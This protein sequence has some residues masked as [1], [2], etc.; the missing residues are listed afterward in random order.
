MAMIVRKYDIPISY[1]WYKIVIE[2]E[3]ESGRRKIFLDSALKVEDQ[4]YQLVAQILDIEGTKIL[5]KDFDDTFGSKTLDQHIYD[6]SLTHATWEVTLPGAAKTKVV[7]NK[8]PKEETV[9]FR[10]KKLP[11]IT[12]TNV[13][14][15]FCN[16]EWSYQEVQ[17]KIEFR[18]ERTWTG[19]LVMD[20]SIVPHFIPSTG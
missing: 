12:R 8:E 10:G 19:T 9:Y 17:F 7:A 14:A 3:K 6:H 18:L 15:A 13:F 5:I 2:V 20:K 11:G 16:L 4:V 1:R